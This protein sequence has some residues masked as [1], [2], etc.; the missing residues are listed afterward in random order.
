M[1]QKLPIKT[2]LFLYLLNTKRWISSNYWDLM[3]EWA[4]PACYKIKG[5]R[6]VARGWRYC[7]KCNELYIQGG[8]QTR[9]MHKLWTIELDE[10]VAGLELPS[11]LTVPDGAWVKL[12]GGKIGLVKVVACQ[13]YV[14]LV[15]AGMSVA[16][17][18]A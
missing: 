9:D 13:D 16:G 6:K 14:F 10:S 12:P 11:G 3:L 15:S 1:S 5:T 17:E 2:R 8:I 4:C 7:Q 18:A